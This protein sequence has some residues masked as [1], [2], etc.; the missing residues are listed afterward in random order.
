M[1]DFIQFLL[2]GMGTGSI[3]AL[4][5]L[6]LVLVYRGSGVVNFSQGALALSGA[7]FFYEAHKHTPVVVAIVIATMGCAVIGA[8]IQLLVMGPMRGSSP[9]ARLIATLALLTVGL[10]TWDRVY[11]NPVAP[12]Q[13]LP[14]AS[15]DL[16]G[17]ILIPQSRLLLLLIV[18]ALSVG[19]WFFFRST[20]FG[21]ATTAVAENEQ[22]AAAQGWSPNLIAM[23][24]WALGG[25]LAG[26][27]GALLFG[28]LGIEPVGHTL[29]VIPALAAALLGGF[30][31][32]L[33]VVAGA[34]ALGAAQSLALL[35]IDETGVT[36][37][38]RS[39]IPFL[40]IVLVLVVRGRSLPL[41]SFAADRLPTLGTGRVRPWMVAAAGAATIASLHAFDV[42]WSRSVIV[43]TYFGIVALSLVVLVGFAGQLSLAQWAVAGMGAL[44]AGR[45]AADIW[46]LPTWLSIIVGVALTIPVGLVISLPALRIRGVNLAIITLALAV[47]IDSMIL[48]NNQYTT[49]GF[50][51]AKIPDPSIFGIDL[52]AREHPERFATFGV[53]LFVIAGLM[54]ANLR[55]GQI[56][57]RMI[58]VR[59]NENA[60]ASLGISVLH[61]KAYAFAVAS[62]LAAL[63]GALIAFSNS[64]LVFESSFPRMRNIEIVLFSVLGGVGYLGGAIAAGAGAVGGIAEH[65][66]GLVIDT[67]DWWRLIAAVLVVAFVI[68]RPNGG[69]AYVVKDFAAM[70]RST[71]SKLLNV[72][73]L[74]LVI[75]LVAIHTTWTPE[76]LSGPDFSRVSTVRFVLAF[77]VLVAVIGARRE[78]QIVPAVV[79]AVVGLAGVAATASLGDDVELGGTWRW[80]VTGC[81][82]AAFGGAMVVAK[83]IAERDRPD[84]IRLDRSASVTRVE[85]RTLTLDGVTVAFGSVVALSDARL[86]VRPG[87]VTGL[88]GPNGAGKTTLIEAVTGF[89]DARG[90]IA[91]D[92]EDITRFSPTKRSR[93]GI[94]RSFQSLEL[95]EDM[96]VLDN[97]RTAA[98]AGSSTPYI[99]DLIWPRSP[100][101]TESAIAAIDEF[102]LADVLHEKPSEL[103]YAKRRM[104]AIARALAAGP[105]VILLDEPAAGL[106]AASTTELEHLIRRLADD[107][108]MAVLLI[109]HDV[110]LVMRTCDRITALNFGAVIAE[111]TPDEIARSETVIASYL[112]EPDDGEP[113]V[114]NRRDEERSGADERSDDTVVDAQH[115]E[116]IA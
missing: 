101:L 96:T 98:D 46:G 99:T 112:G 30:R 111:G 115:A 4:V 44:F 77:G 37:G 63:G 16:G 113:D 31:S 43:G 81:V 45:L 20:R 10:E 105:S 21:L 8:L 93:V 103:P 106:D 11:P 64:N 53:V 26:L 82:V 1:N 69:A 70:T 100:E 75:S 55:R 65:L 68:F 2:L 86:T 94:A 80:T 34:L 54:M 58:A 33:G 52:T 32:Y 59:G 5:A 38:A 50:V 109:E 47:V 74:G 104:V 66:V 49:D 22:V 12:V 108:G 89:V 91:L 7:A 15:V 48:T 84:V 102:D 14:D 79:T 40:A 116:V 17:G 29:I 76:G 62:G 87:E 95:F 35:Y 18:V 23:S 88:I 51:P 28:L 42:S 6:G 61:V 110:G 57:R 24:N 9:L 97:L 36:K 56:G 90:R 27:G 71:M 60:A 25:A 83:T 114:G 19:L 85:P 39:A 67:K 92:G 3:Y 41:R 78:K 107:W 73:A 72:A 13:F